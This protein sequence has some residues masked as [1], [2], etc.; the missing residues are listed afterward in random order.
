MESYACN[1]FWQFVSSHLTDDC[2]ALRL[3]YLGKTQAKHPAQGTDGTADCTVSDYRLAI[4][5][6]ECRQ[7]FGKK[8]T[9]TLPR[10]DRFL[11]ATV[12]AG[13]Q[14]TSDTLAAWH[15]TLV[16]PGLAVVDMTAGLGI[17]ILHLASKAVTAVA[18]ERQQALADALVWNAKGLGA[19]NLTV[20]CGDSMELLAQRKLTGNVLFAD[21][22]R[23]ADDGARVFALADCEPDAR[24]IVEL[25]RECGFARVILKLSPM[26]DITAT[27]R[28]LPACTDI[29]A[30]GTRTECKELVATVDLNAD[31]P[32]A[33]DVNVHAVTLTGVD[34]ESPVTLSC[35]LQALSG[36]L[37]QPA[38]GMPKAGDWVT[39]PWP[40]V[41][42]AA[43]YNVYCNEYGLTPVSAN[44]HVFWSTDKPATAAGQA[45]RVIDVVPWQS[46][47]IKRFKSRYP[48][49]QVAVRN[50]G[51]SAEALRQRLDV[52]QGNG[53]VRVIGVTDAAGNRQLIVVE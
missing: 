34:D 18:V 35:P 25:A 46:R 14:C 32:T 30:V 24:R 42:K 47:N 11:F 39:E 53:A 52:R 28:D 13:E 29:Y 49:A 33:N 9:A 6:I 17:D 2:A 37:P 5:Q 7:R 10:F 16:A 21:P 23:R 41:M 43:A 26:L 36:A 19:D 12:L 50:F 8:L 45:R 31:S 20:L 40:A 51:M 48:L 27:A 1:S 15:A 22:A 4:T 3:K 44:S 38:A